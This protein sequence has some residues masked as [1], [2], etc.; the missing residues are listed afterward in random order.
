MK[1]TLHMHRALKYASDMKRLEEQGYLLIL[2]LRPGETFWELNNTNDGYYI[3]P[4]IA[5]SLQHCLYVLERLGKITF[6]NEQDAKNEL[7]KLN[8]EGEKCD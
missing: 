1:D 3:Y 8:K 2:P 6:L 7:N 4:R 5:H